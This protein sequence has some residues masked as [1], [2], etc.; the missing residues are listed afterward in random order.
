MKSARSALYW[1]T[2]SL[3]C[4]AVYWHGL[5][6]WF[7]ADDF[8][9]LSLISNV[10]S[11]S[12]F[13]RSMFAPMAQGTIRPWS[14]RAFFMAFYGLFGLDA[15]PFRIWVFLTQFANLLL[16]ASIAWKLTGSRAAGFLATLFWIANIA[17]AKVMTWTSVYNQVLSAFFLLA[18]FYALLLH[19]ET[20]KRSYYL[21]QWAAFLLGFGALEIN[22]VYPALAA[23]Y[24]FLCAKKYFWRTLP[25]F[26]A[27]VIFVILHSKAVALPSSG[28]YIM[29]FD[30][31]MLKT[32]RTYWEWSLGPNW[33]V[34]VANVPPWI[35]PAGTVLLTAALLGF[36]AFRAMRKQWLPL[37]LLAW[38]V[39][40]LAPVLPLRDHLTEYY[41]FLP[42]IGLAILGAWASVY[43]WRRGIGWKTLA[44][45]SAAVYLS[46]SLPA[47]RISSIWIYERSREVR[48]LV[49]GVARAHE[50][51]PN[52]VILLSGVGDSLFWNGILDRPFRLLG[53]A[54]VY[55]T[56]GSES[57]IQAHPELGNI[58]EYILPPGPTLRAM[59][60]EQAVVYAAG[61]DRLKNITRAYELSA[62]LHLKFQA[63]RRVDVANP[64]MDY[65]LG[66]EWYP[67]DGDHRWMPK[68]ATLKIAGPAAPAEKLYITGACPDA[69]TQ[70]GRV[71]VALTADGYALAPL[72]I[73]PGRESFEFEI[74]LPGALTGKDAIEVS[75]Q[76][77]RT[78]KPAGD[79]RELGLS[80]GVFEIR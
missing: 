76:V 62:P 24:T 72:S 66:P 46:T 64:L 65:L 56:P 34:Q 27:S 13:W 59:E 26:L 20:G 53:I 17:L 37:V 15:L 3:I 7:Q 79:Q 54:D 43:G 22:V 30:S 48:Q 28:A 21:W 33:L 40:T 74:A 75:I 36:V 52:K 77:N 38:F 31:S 80:F 23:T 42:S 8:A 2:P 11:W 63:P 60:R 19:I 57:S 5:K 61:G 6:A 58:A 71:E 18:A 44:S 69:L 4:L 16:I 55:L 14:E 73:L 50:L 39:I 10:H 35:S 25:L 68:R 47:T 12:D 32:L 51:H 9:W 29:Y 49:L 70:S 41:L 45:L 78:I 67:R 1:I